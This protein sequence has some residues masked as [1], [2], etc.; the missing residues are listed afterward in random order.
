MDPSGHI[1]ATFGVK[2]Y[3]DLELGYT[4]QLYKKIKV[5]KVD[6]KVR[7]KFSNYSYKVYFYKN[8]NVKVS[9]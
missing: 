1:I 5:K 2:V 3:W 7:V 4:K 6:G 9:V 8:G